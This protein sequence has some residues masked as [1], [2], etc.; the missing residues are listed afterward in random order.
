MNVRIKKSENESWVK[1]KW[2]PALAWIYGIVILF[3]FIVAPILWT[4]TQVNAQDFGMAAQQW[5]PL[6]L[7]Q[8]GL[9]HLSMGAILGVTAWS[10]GKE[11]VA[12]VSGDYYP[13][14]YYSETEYEEQKPFTQPSPNPEGEI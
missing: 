10:R 2:R 4:M 6:T 14:A 7:G 8:G 11:K 12:G 1:S 3:D 5:V 9:F 13:T